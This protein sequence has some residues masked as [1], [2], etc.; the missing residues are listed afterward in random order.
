MWA[1]AAR[2][3]DEG[4]VV[5]SYQRGKVIRMVIFIP[6]FFFLFCA[7]CVF[8]CFTFVCFLCPFFFC[9]V[10]RFVSA[11]FPLLVP[12][13]VLFFSGACFGCIAV[14]QD[15]DTRA[16]TSERTYIRR[17]ETNSEVY[18]VSKY[19]KEKEKS[20]GEKR[21]RYACFIIIIIATHQSIA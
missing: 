20:T 17:P 6:F 5:S 11:S 1:V 12:V 18:W 16:R 7:F 3:F 21:C 15:E 10:F 2:W 14:V 9:S 8:L 4:M 19:E 13:S